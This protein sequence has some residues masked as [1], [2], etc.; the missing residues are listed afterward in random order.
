MTAEMLDRYTGKY[1]SSGREIVIRREGSQLIAHIFGRPNLEMVP[2]SKQE[3]TLRWTD[4]NLVFDLNANGAATG[5]TLRVGRTEFPAKK[6][7]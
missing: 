4:A 7:Q 3:F 6:V 5:L 2:H 1:D